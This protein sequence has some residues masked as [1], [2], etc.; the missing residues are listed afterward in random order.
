MYTIS[1][2]AA[3]AVAAVVIAA[4]FASLNAMRLKF[5]RAMVSFFSYFFFYIVVKQ[6]FKI[7]VKLSNRFLFLCIM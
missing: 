6:R 5:D 1:R 7:A 2:C 3:A 4:L